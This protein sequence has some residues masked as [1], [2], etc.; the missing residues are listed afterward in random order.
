MVS[1]SVVSLIAIVP[2]SECNTPI[3]IVPPVCAVAASGM[4]PMTAAAAAAAQI[5]FSTLVSLS[6]CLEAAERPA[7]PRG[8]KIEA[9]ARPRDEIGGRSALFSYPMPNQWAGF[10]SAGE[11]RATDVSSSPE[12]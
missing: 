12:T 10:R 1:F 3:L 8:S 6:M 5:L 7:L 2:D 9:K 4:P 11:M